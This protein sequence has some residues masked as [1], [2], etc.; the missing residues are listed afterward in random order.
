MQSIRQA[1]TVFGRLMCP[2]L[3]FKIVTYIMDGK[4]NP[5]SSTWIHIFSHEY[6]K[7]KKKKKK[8]KYELSHLKA[9][10]SIILRSLN[11]NELLQS[12][13]YRKLCL[14]VTKNNQADKM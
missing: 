12:L 3:S 6:K 5:T 11:Q 13:C 2:S 4:W 7:K 10:S 1:L 9:D 14:Q 8:K